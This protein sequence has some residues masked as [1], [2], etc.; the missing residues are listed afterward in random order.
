MSMTVEICIFLQLRPRWPSYYILK[1][2][3]M[4]MENQKK[5]GKMA[6]VTPMLAIL[7]E[8]ENVVV[9]FQYLV[10]G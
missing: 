3:L 6:W 7:P 10:G 1:S 9:M 2:G 8:V 4:M 5:T